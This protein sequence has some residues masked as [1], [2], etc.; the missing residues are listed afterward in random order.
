MVRR[1][2]TKLSCLGT[3]G[4]KFAP[5]TAD[6]RW[7][8]PWAHKRNQPRKTQSSHYA[9]SQTYYAISQT[10]NE[11][12]PWVRAMTSVKGES[13]APGFRPGSRL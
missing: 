7:E 5:G 9:I 6:D 13:K 11:A 10:Y 2:R 3:R 12:M 4:L 8:K 1:K